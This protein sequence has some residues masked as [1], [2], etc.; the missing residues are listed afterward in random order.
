MMSLGGFLVWVVPFHF[1]TGCALRLTKS[2][3]R[4]LIDIT[5]VI[6]DDAIHPRPSGPVV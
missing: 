3:S 6:Y 5:A 1:L 4:T 2:Q